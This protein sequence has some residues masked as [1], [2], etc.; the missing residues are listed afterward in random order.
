M[1]TPRSAFVQSKIVPP[2]PLPKGLTSDKLI[3]NKEYYIVSRLVDPKSTT[4]DPEPQVFNK[5][6][7][8]G[9]L[10]FTKKDGSIAEYHPRYTF[11]YQNI[12]NFTNYKNPWKNGAP[13]GFKEGG[14][15]STRKRGYRRNSSQLRTHR[16]HQTRF[17][18]S[19]IR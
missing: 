1:P 14:R 7:E 5:I 6:S 18:S 13:P 15:R 3:Q 12:R 19:K 10:E 4:L 11:I 16:S 17:R 8:D 9:I 2:I